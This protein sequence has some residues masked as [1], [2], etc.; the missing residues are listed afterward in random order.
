MAIAIVASVV[1]MVVGYG[2]AQ[3][4]VLW[5]VGGDWLLV[6]HSVSLFALYLIAASVGKTWSTTMVAHPQL[7][8]VKSWSVGH[9][10]INGDVQSLI[11]FG[12]LLAWAAL[13]VVVI[14]KQ[15]GKPAP[16]VTVR[17]LNEVVTAVAAI[18]AF[19]GIAFIHVALGYA[20]YLP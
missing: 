8:A 15:D 1:L 2:H 16:E 19:G 6:S 4:K 10:L 20:V 17:A 3:G 14:N 13:S 9:L 18:L 5:V 12:G 7:T 11:L